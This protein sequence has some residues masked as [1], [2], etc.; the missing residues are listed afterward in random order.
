[1]YIWNLHTFEQAFCLYLLNPSLLFGIEWNPRHLQSGD[2][3]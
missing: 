2:E 1:M 3:P